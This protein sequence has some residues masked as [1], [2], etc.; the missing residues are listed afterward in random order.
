MNLG[1]KIPAGTF[2]DVSPYALHRHPD[3]WTD[4]E[5]FNPDR[6]IQENEETKYAFLPFGTGL[7]SCIGDRFILYQMLI[8]TAK[9]FSRLEFTLDPGYNME[10][11]K[12]NFFLT[13]KHLWVKINLRKL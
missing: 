5:K 1:I 4:P 9:I 2:V 3:Y 12:G 11:F 10:Y 7:R 6:F 8:F 13:P